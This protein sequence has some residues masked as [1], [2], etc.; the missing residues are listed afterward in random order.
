MKTKTDQWDIGRDLDTSWK[1]E[2]KYLGSFIDTEADIHNRK[3]LAN[4]GGSW[5]KL[6]TRRM[7]NDKKRFRDHPPPPPP[8]EKIDMKP[9]LPPTT[10]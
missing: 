10:P 3:C 4:R 7:E 1:E 2:F 8:P 9:N 6:T 5:K